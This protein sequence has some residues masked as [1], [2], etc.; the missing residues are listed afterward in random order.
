MAHDMEW[1]QVVSSDLGIIIITADDCVHCIELQAALNERPLDF[2][3][4]WVDKKNAGEIF[5]QFPLFA[6]SVD[7]LPFVGIFSRGEGEAVVRAATPQRIAEAL[8]EL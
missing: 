3:S 5:A 7:V 2:P 4:L 6:T 1:S 8:A